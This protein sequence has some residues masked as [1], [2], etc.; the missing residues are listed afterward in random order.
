MIFLSDCPAEVVVDSNDWEHFIQSFSKTYATPDEFRACCRDLA[1][2]REFKRRTDRVQQTPWAPYNLRLFKQTFYGMAHLLSPLVEQELVCVL[3][4]QQA[5]CGKSW[6]LEVCRPASSLKKLGLGQPY[7]R[8]NQ[9]AQAVR[10]QILDKLEETV[11]IHRISSEIRS[12]V[13]ADSEG[14]ALDSILAAVATFRTLRHLHAPL[15]DW[16]EA[17]PVEGYVY[18]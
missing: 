13:V 11:D 7:K 5:L 18:A 6:L 12:K 15:P 17:Y 3:P 14:D 4:M 16:Y 8:S 10:A 2:N 1:N 9:P